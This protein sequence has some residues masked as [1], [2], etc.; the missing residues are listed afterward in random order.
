MLYQSKRGAKFDKFV[1]DRKSELSKIGDMKV[2][3]C[4][5]DPE[6]EII[7]LPVNDQPVGYEEDEWTE[8]WAAKAI[9]G[10]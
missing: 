8:D 4:N 3:A 9:S 7:E 1:K 10:L 6:V 5:Q 2:T